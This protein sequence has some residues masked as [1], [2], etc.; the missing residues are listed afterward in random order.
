MNKKIGQVKVTDF[1]NFKP[2]NNYNDSNEILRINIDSD[3]YSFLLKNIENPPE[4]LYAMGNISLLNKP[5]IAIVGT[6]K[7]TNDGKKSANKIANFYAKKGYVI[8]SGLAFGVDTIAMTNA[9]SINAPVIGVLPS[10]VD[11]V[12]PK[13]NRPLAEKIIKKGGLLIS[14]YFEGDR[15][16]KS[17]YVER[18]RIIS[19]IAYQTIIVETSADG[20]TM[21]T[22]K[23]AKSQKRPIVVADLPVEGNQM[24]KKEGYPI[25]PIKDK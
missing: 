13:K 17:Q 8:V 23:F 25:I 21:H 12:M 1:E 15:V 9:V 14:E 24:L 10:P 5:A 6:R 22:V 19:G 18:N 3:E 7:P 4:T 11:N 2:S 16:F 20:G